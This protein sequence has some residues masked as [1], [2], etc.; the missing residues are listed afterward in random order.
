MSDNTVKLLKVPGNGQISI[1]KKWAGRNI[2]MEIVSEHEIR[3]VSG[4]F[5]PD[6]QMAFHD[7]ESMET[8]ALF[9][10]WCEGNEP[11][12]TDRKKLRKTLGK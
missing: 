12:K 10:K 9:N 5:V 11:R 4:S 1:G 2:C 7:K 6:H 8:L 3:I